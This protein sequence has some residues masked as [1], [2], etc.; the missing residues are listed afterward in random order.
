[1]SASVR[2]CLLLRKRVQE[3]DGYAKEKHAQMGRNAVCFIVSI[4]FHEKEYVYLPLF[5]SSCF[6]RPSNLDLNFFLPI[7]GAL[8]LCTAWVP[9]VWIHSSLY[10][11]VFLCPVVIL[12][13]TFVSGSGSGG[14]EPS[15]WFCRRGL[16]WRWLVIQAR[17]KRKIKKKIK[18]FFCSGRGKMW[19]SLPPSSWVWLTKLLLDKN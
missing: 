15:C 10:K 5:P 9:T 7:S 1:M 2:P 12:P 6:L 17:R 4:Y 8:D 14:E 19:G 18:S 11:F 13:L 16:V 3:K